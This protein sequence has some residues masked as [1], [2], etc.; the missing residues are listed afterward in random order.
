MPTLDQL[1]D[2]AKQFEISDPINWEDLSIE[3]DAAYRLVAAN[4]LEF[5]NN[6]G[7]MEEQNHILLACVVKLSIENFLLNIK[8][9]QR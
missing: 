3:Q 1:V 4:I 2:L 9:L 7:T 5:Y 6:I 8:I